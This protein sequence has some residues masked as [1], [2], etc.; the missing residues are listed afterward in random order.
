MSQ[1]TIEIEFENTNDEEIA[2]HQFI[3]FSS[4]SDTDTE[5]EQLA[6]GICSQN[7]G[8]NI[9]QG[10]LN[11]VSEEANNLNQQDL[12]MNE[13]AI[14]PPQV[15]QGYIIEEDRNI[16][17]DDQNGVS[18]EAINLSQD[19]QNITNGQVLSQDPQKYILAE[20][21]IVELHQKR[22]GSIFEQATIVGQREIKQRNLVFR[23]FRE[24]PILM[25]ISDD[26]EMIASA[27]YETVEIANEIITS[28]LQIDFKVQRQLI[29]SNMWLNKNNKYSVITSETKKKHTEHKYQT[30][31]I[32]VQLLQFQ[33]REVEATRTFSKYPKDKWTL[34]VL[35]GHGS[36]AD[37]R[38]IHLLQQHFIDCVVIPGHSS[39]ILQP[40]DV[41]VFK[42]FKQELKKQQRHKKI[43]YL[44]LDHCL[45][46]AT[47][48]MRIVEA[49]NKACIYPL[50]LNKNLNN[51]PIFPAE[52]KE[53]AF[54]N[55][56]KG[57]RLRISGQF[58][59]SEKFI[60]K[61][62]NKEKR[63]K[64]SQRR[65]SRKHIPPSKPFQKLFANMQVPFNHI[66]ISSTISFTFK[67]QI[68]NEI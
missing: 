37:L 4:S 32:L 16:P 24:Y 9:T 53:F 63:I 59:T 41:G 68:F 64:A 57:S 22:I 27:V 47:S 13:Q 50:N 21:E 58:L 11:N 30:G 2:R 23:I 49:F 36:R 39:H 38:A 17:Q 33:Q 54:S 3:E 51:K 10:E 42:Y 56:N 46:L 28:W 20:E 40:L 8:L 43:F 66:P 25:L 35:D 48:T 15:D 65:T 29:T 6:N 14:N 55:L 5:K 31:N 60:E 1:N 26:I 52:I 62:T 34:L 44:V 45:N 18:E 61:L 7:E 19:D 12:N 67:A